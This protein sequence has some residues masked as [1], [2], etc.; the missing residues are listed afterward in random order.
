LEN[1]V[2]WRIIKGLEELF[3][4]Y[5]NPPFFFYKVLILFGGRGLFP[6]NNWVFH[7]LF[8]LEKFFGV[9]PRNSPKEWGLL[10]QLILG[11]FP[12]NFVG[13]FPSKNWAGKFPAPSFFF[14]LFPQRS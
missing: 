8:N 9:L 6:K 13:V 7:P 1:C 11:N 12:H 14:T 5:F 10:S 3:S 2:T 4:T